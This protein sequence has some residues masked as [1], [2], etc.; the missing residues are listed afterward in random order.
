MRLSAKITHELLTAETR[1]KKRSRGNRPRLLYFDELLGVLPDAV[2]LHAA[3][4]AELNGETV[5]AWISRAVEDTAAR[6]RMIRDLR[7]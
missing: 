1:Q 5:Q 3:E 6:D 2:R 7:G 4:A